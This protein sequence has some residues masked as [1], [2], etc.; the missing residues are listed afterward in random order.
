MLE[1]DSVLKSHNYKNLLKALYKNCNFVQRRKVN[2]KKIIQNFMNL[3]LQLQRYLYYASHSM[4][5]NYV[6]QYNGLHITACHS[7]E[8][9]LILHGGCRHLAASNILTV[10]NCHKYVKKYCSDSIFP[11][12]LH[13]SFVTSLHLPLTLIKN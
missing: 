10:F 12:K 4:Y 11:K 2:E 3:R 1:T 6:V 13:R 9:L 5:T 7:F 8:A